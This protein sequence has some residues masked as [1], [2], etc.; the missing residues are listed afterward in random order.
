MDAHQLPEQS[1]ADFVGR[2]DGRL[3]F[4]FGRVDPN[5]PL[6]ALG[7]VGRAAFEQLNQ[8][9]GAEGID[10]KAAGQ[11]VWGLDALR[12]DSMVQ[13]EDIQ[14]PQLLEQG[15]LISALPLQPTVGPRLQIR[16]GRR[17]VGESCDMASQGSKAC[18][19][20]LAQG[21]T[22]ACDANAFV[23]PGAGF[24]NGVGHSSS[25]GHP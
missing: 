21:P 24:E 9:P 1:F 5:F 25:L 6:L 12:I 20:S 23:V 16:R 7:P 19:Q 4:G 11:L 18:R 3:N 14:F 8:A 13:D 15:V 22:G 17:A 2:A 10:L